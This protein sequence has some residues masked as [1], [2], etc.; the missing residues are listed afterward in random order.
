N[1]TLF[2]LVL[3]VGIVVDDAIVVVEAVQHQIELGHS[4]REAT[5]RAM[6]DVA[7]PIVAVGVV[8][9][10]V[11]IPCA[12]LGGIIGLFFRQFALTIAVS[13]LISTFNSLSLSPALCAILLKP[14]RET[15]AV[16]KRI[17]PVVNVL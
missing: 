15:S 3:A 16:P 5:V 11:F 8:L 17:A 14:K 2:G 13:T 7:G 12:F 4:P 6:H 9:A 10:A 1:L